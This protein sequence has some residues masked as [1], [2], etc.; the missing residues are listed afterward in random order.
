MISDVLFEALHEIHR[1][2]TE[3][4]IYTEDDTKRAINKVTTLMHALQLL[5]DIGLTDD[6]EQAFF[7]LTVA[8]GDINTDRVIEACK[9][10]RDANNKPVEEKKDATEQKPG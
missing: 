4:D 8:L 9:K 6:T 3:T 5:F 2:Q 10:L 7:E 1:Y